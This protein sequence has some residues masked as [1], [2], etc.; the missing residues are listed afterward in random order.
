MMSPMD[1]LLHVSTTA[2]GATNVVPDVTVFDTVVIVGTSPSGMIL[3]P[4]AN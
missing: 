4:R 2:I 1:P 3:T